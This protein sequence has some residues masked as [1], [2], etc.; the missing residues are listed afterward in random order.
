M[1]Y[2]LRDKIIKELIILP[3]PPISPL[4]NE[5]GK[6]ISYFEKL[7]DMASVY[8]KQYDIILDF[9]GYKETLI[10]YSN[11]REDE[12]DIAWRL[13]KELNAWTEY[14][15]SIANLIQKLH[16][17]AECDKLEIQAIAS[18]QADSTKVANGDR[19]ANRDSNVIAIRKKRNTLKSFYDELEAKSKFLERAYYHCKATCDWVNKSNN[20][21]NS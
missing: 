3:K 21:S 17:D 16:L 5:E 8:L 15:T 2:T 10:D 20:N 18:I 11:L 12:A 1:I 4:K 6:S 7:A 13:T 19:L 9:S 14:F